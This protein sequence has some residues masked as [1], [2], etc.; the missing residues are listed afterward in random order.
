M[1]NFILLRHPE[2]KL[3][4]LKNHGLREGNVLNISYLKIINEKDK[5]MMQS[6]V[7]FK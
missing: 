1:K 7:K 5:E 4:N 2:K 6:K 3:S